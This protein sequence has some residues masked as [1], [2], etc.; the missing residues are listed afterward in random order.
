MSGEW[1]ESLLGAVCACAAVGAILCM[2]TCCQKNW[3]V[4]MKREIV[5][6]ETDQVAIK[7][8]LVRGPNGWG[9]PT[10]TTP[11]MTAPVEAAK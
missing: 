2:T 8:G 10:I 4:L 9:S 3:E 1:H 11:V 5:Q 7:A 6:L